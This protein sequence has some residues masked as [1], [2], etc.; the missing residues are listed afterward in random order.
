MPEKK[1]SITHEQWSVAQS[2][3]IE[4]RYWVYPLTAIIYR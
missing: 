1:F 3:L 2:V 4:T